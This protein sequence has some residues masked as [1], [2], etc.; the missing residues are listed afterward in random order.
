[1]AVLLSETS[2]IL[3]PGHFLESD[4]AYDVIT[5]HRGFLNAGVIEMPMRETNLLDL[6]EKKRSEYGSVRHRF[7]GLFDDA[8]MNLFE[9][10]TPFFTP[11]A[12]RIGREATKNWEEG[13]DVNPEWEG[14]ARLLSTDTLEELRNGPKRLIE[15]GEALTWPALLPHLSGEVK[16]SSVPVRIVL[17]K[18]YF[19]LY[20]DEYRA[21]FLSDLPYGF[22]V[23]LSDDDERYYSYHGF[24]R[25]L[26]ALRCRELICLPIEGLIRLKANAGWTAFADVFVQIIAGAD[27]PTNVTAAFSRSATEVGFNG[28]A[29][30]SELVEGLSAGQ[31]LATVDELSDAL[32]S[33]SARMSTEHG[34]IV[35]TAIEPAP[36]S[37]VTPS[38]FRPEG[39]TQV[40]RV[41]DPQ[42][43]MTR[44][45]IATS[46]ER[47][48]RAVREALIGEVGGRRRE[49]RR[50][51]S[52]PSVHNR[53]AD[54]AGS[55]GHR[56]RPR[57]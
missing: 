26:S 31:V 11:R 55:S 49:I 4:V 19:K 3:P 57:R 38:P 36:G 18:N 12:T 44:V 54:E 17:Q 48:T 23:Y 13:P 15:S 40:R 42:R 43:P 8:R 21:A 10:V 28:L 46:N 41:G 33:L 50:S 32:A 53:A 39:N 47:E 1:M 14:L 7:P 56:P 30:Q 6:I 27:T 34:L 22:D 52:G 5:R 25:V 20:L 37:P 2:A 51:R 9:D 29:I 35:R 24:L 45:L 16:H